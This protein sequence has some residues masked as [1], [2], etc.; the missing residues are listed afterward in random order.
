M[1]SRIGK[2]GLQRISVRASTRSEAQSVVGLSHAWLHGW[3]EVACT[4]K[5]CQILLDEF[6]CVLYNTCGKKL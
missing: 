2:E 4:G 1:D 5:Q 6:T 3:P